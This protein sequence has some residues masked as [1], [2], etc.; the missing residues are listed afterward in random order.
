MALVTL[1]Y[2]G[3][4][5]YRRSVTVECEDI[6]TTNQFI[7]RLMQVKICIMTEK[8]VINRTG[9][10][11]FTI[12]RSV[13]NLTLSWN[14]KIHYLPENVHES[15]PNLIALEAES[16]RIK[17]ISRKNF[18]GL[19]RLKILRLA[20]NMISTVEPGLF[21]DNSELKIIDLSEL[22]ALNCNKK[23]IKNY[24]SLFRRQSN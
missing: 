3:Y 22:D 8:T 23:F 24:C 7:E 12:D 4:R 11:V 10:E 17:Q 6:Q 1:T 18:H 21:G 9:I 2:F 20:G 15:F 19:H 16:C 14:N 5:A 13:Q